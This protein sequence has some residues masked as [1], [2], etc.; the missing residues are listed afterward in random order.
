MP[1]K[2][3]EMLTF[4]ADL[5]HS[6]EADVEFVLKTIE[7]LPSAREQAVEMNSFGSRAVYMQALYYTC[8]FYTTY[9]FATVNRL[10]QQA[11]GKTYFPIIFLHAILIPLQGFF[12]GQ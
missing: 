2:L 10:V 3:S 5:K 12:N 11:T 8:A 9:T 6:D 7:S 4:Q 1:T